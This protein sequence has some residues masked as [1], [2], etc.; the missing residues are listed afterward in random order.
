MFNIYDMMKSGMSAE[1]IAAEFTQNLN[2]AE[3]KVRAEEA[4]AARLAEEAVRAEQERIDARAAKHQE[5]EEAIGDLLC[6]IARH[7]PELGLDVE[8]ITSESVEGMTNLV[9]MI[10][11]LEAMKRHRLKITAEIKRDQEVRPTVLKGVPADDPFAAF[12]KQFGL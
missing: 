10:L 6:A 2:E 4:E 5:F 8:D 3:A 1:E 11:D 9:L 12:F 7:Y